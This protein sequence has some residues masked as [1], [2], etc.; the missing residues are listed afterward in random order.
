MICDSATGDGTA[1]ISSWVVLG[2]AVMTIVGRRRIT[3]LSVLPLKGTG[4]VSATAFDSFDSESF[5][6]G[7][8]ASEISS[9]LFSAGVLC[10]WEIES[11][12]V[13]S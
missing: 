8:V 13:W 10:S 9:A 12:E 2:T 6:A 11:G 1:S 7:A 3:A 5:G 4:I